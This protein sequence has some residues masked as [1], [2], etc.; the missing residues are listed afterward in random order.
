MTALQTIMSRL[1]LG[2]AGK[3]TPAANDRRSRPD[4]RSN[5]ARDNV[6]LLHG[7]E[8]RLQFAARAIGFGTY[9][10]DSN[11]GEIHWSPE[12]KAMAGL[13][14]DDTPLS[15]EKIGELIHP[16]D[17]E[18]VMASFN[19]SFDPNNRTN[20][21]DEECRLLQPDGSTR[22]VSLR[23]RALFFG[24]G[25]TRQI[26]GAT[27]VVVDISASRAAEEQLQRQAG[28]IDLAPDPLMVWDQRHGI[29]FWNAACERIYGYTREEA[30]G[31]ACHE[32]LKADFPVSRQASLTELAL[33]GRWAGTVHYTTRD[34]HRI[35]VEIRLERMKHDGHV[36]ILEA[37][38]C[39]GESPPPYP[40]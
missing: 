36:S 23:G 5:E 1:G 28:L 35:P 16:D 12:L 24:H 30:L 4:R 29:V 15:L 33:H 25:S 18:R 17:R 22:L 14:Q 2:E 26:L 11:T 27:G 7:T 10:L 32:L 20:E 8:S 31:Q 6:F 40:Q 13:P 38:R 19:A 34:G 9:D 21:I 37:D 39:L 3:E